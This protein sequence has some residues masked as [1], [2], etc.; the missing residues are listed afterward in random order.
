MIDG[1]RTVFLHE[2][3]GFWRSGIFALMMCIVGAIGLGTA[4]IE[5]RAWSQEQAERAALQAQETAQWLKLEDTHIHKAAH[6]GYFVIRDLPPGIILDRGVW[7]F[8][9]S[10]IWLEAH[11]RNAPRL[12]AADAAGL[13]ARGSP[14]GIG[15]VLLWLMPLLIAVLTH[16]VIAG[17]RAR[18]SLAFAVSSG[19][20]PSAIVT[21][22]ALAITTLS[23]AAAAV[24]LLAGLSMALASGLA[25]ANAA[26]WVLTVLSALGVFCILT[27]MIS[28]LARRPFG[29]LTALLL[30]WFAMAVLW[31]RLAA[32]ITAQ[33]APTPSSQTIRSKAEVAAEGLVSE[34]TREQL[35]AR[36]AAQGITAPNASGVSALAAEID[37]ARAF[38]Q[39]FA[40]LE[41]AMTR[42][43]DLLDILSWASPLAAA[44]RAADAALGLSDR[45][46]FS[47]EARAEAMRLATQ[48]TLNEDWARSERGA[49]G[50]PATWRQVVDAAN[51]VA[52][53]PAGASRAGVGV[54]LWGV[55][56]LA[57]LVLAT[58]A[59][60]RSI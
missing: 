38:T 24:P 58:R 27:V 8:G 28:S 25:A 52:V 56:C 15:P 57:G 20:S 53:P 51:A 54:A 42:Q 30:I 16:G 33:I 1:V 45:H 13:I 60:R 32:G 40:P 41:A 44:D 4:V 5:Y 9:G 36:L 46:Q 43:S 47:F 17:E 14:R 21:G 29:A 11:R 37:A 3:A 34:A 55:L 39:I 7:D 12:R 31:P 6:R 22:K 59:V 48:R 19:A 26:V 50:D 23:W 10:A 49:R 2:W 18:G 35:L